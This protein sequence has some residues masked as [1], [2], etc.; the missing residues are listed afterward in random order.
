MRFFSSLI[1]QSRKYVVGGKLV[2][3]FVLIKVDGMK[4]SIKLGELRTSLVPFHSDLVQRNVKFFFSFTS[5]RSLLR[6]LM[7]FWLGI[8]SPNAAMTGTRGRE[9]EGKGGEEEK[10]ESGRGLEATLTTQETRG[11]FCIYME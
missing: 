10:E 3:I 8:R 4:V 1:S 6:I 11:S 7:G 9:K 5:N 2:A